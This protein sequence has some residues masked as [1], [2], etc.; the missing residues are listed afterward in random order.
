MLGAIAGFD[1]RDGGSVERPVPDYRAAL[2]P[3]IRGM[4]VGVVRHFWEQDLKTHEQ[5]ARA[6]DA[7]LGVLE[8]LGAK[9]E[10]ARMRPMQHYTDVKMVIAETEL[11]SVHHKDL[12]A[13]PHDFGINFLAQTLTGCLFQSV[14]Y[15]AAQREHRRMIA[16]MRPLYEKHDVL[17]TV[18]SGPAPRFDEFS[19]LNMWVKPHPHTAFSVT[20]GPA[21]ALCNGFTSDGLPLS[22]QIAGAP[23]AE[24]KVLRVAYAYEQATPWRG[25]RPKL[26][27]GASRVPVTQPPAL[28]GIEVDAATRAQVEIL[29]R[30]AGLKLDHTQLQLLCEVAPYAFAMAARIPRDHEWREEPSGMFR[31]PSSRSDLISSSGA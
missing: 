18:S 27:P 23:F 6:M 5:L 15:V 21:I 31:V 28:S 29:A 24:E 20:A 14:E 4:R 9:I 1:P 12:I 13:R 2:S 30:R 22:M 10:N 11:F 17:V 26:V 25:R 7:A 16:E 3:D 19:P 8:H